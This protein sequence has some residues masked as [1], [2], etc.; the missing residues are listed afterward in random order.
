MQKYVVERELK[1]AGSLSREELRTIA[2]KS[3]AVLAAMEPRVQWV[4]SFVTPDKIYCIYLGEDAD[5]IRE[6][7]RCGGFPANVVTPVENMFD[8]TT[9]N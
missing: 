9:A 4:Q 5:A 6:H 7:A 3:N 2:L 1:G 8:P